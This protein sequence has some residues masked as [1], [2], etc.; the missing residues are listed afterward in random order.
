MKHSKQ[1]CQTSQAVAQGPLAT[2]VSATSLSRQPHYSLKLTVQINM[3]ILHENMTTL[4]FALYL[5]GNPSM[6]PLNNHRL[7]FVTTGYTPKQW[8]AADVA[9]SGW[10]QTTHSTMEERMPTSFFEHC[11]C[12]ETKQ[13]SCTHLNKTHTHTQCKRA[14]QKCRRLSSAWKT[15]NRKF[16]LSTGIWPCTLTPHLAGSENR[17]GELWLALPDNR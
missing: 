17:V 13:R 15:G 9:R 5:Y 6:E 3:P 11:T 2:C 4:I 16:L 1:L 10:A 14:A 7:L 8:S 12:C